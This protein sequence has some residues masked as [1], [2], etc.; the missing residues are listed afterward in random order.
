M[1][2]LESSKL[3]PFDHRAVDREGLLGQPGISMT[4]EESVLKDDGMHVFGW[5]GGEYHPPE[6]L[7]AEMDGIKRHGN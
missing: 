4:L 7:I 2:Q 6:E 3:L 5:W 1:F